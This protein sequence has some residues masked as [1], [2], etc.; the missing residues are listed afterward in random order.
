MNDPTTVSLS[1][2]FGLD[3]TTYAVI[4]FLLTYSLI[5]IERV[6]RAIIA[7]LAAGLMILGGVITQEAAIKGV[8]FN[9]IGLLTGMMIIVV[10]TRRSGIFQFL[11]IWSAKKVKADPIGLL[12][13]LVIVTALLSGLLDN[14]TTV[15]LIVPVTLLITD[16]LKLSPYPYLFAE[17]FASNIGGAA[18]LIGDPPNIMIGSAVGLSFNDF[19]FNL[20]P[21]ILVIL[22]LTLIPIYLIWGHQLKTTDKLRQ[23][24]MD[25]KEREAITDFPLLWKSLLV[26][27]LVMAG[28]IFAHP[29]GYE[30]ATIAMAGAALLMLLD[31]LPT[32]INEQ[33]EVVHKTY[34]DI[35]WTTIFFFI[36]IFI[37]VAG[38]ESTGTLDTIAHQVLQLTNS[39]PT[40][41]ALSILWV[42]A[43]ASAIIDNIPF[44]ATMIPLIEGMAEQM[45]G[46]DQLMPLWWSLALGS[47]LGGNGSLVGASANLIVAGFAERAGQPI[48]FLPFILIAFP[49]MLFSIVISS[50]YIYWRY[51]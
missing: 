29:W 11:A 16:E 9:T 3:V 35:E 15:L 1:A 33:A 17:I 28:F 40:V 23:R 44:V 32:S 49:L 42:S 41:T 27:L 38:L 18:T 26:L 36:C 30:P 45:G 51:L 50:F 14:V 5:L 24:V 21:I 7:M 48:R 20:G 37:V 19:L 43:I 2:L 34:A 6:N 4:I 8:D 10:I 31:N 22:P 39:D 12:F 25:Y 47:C 46:N 13:M